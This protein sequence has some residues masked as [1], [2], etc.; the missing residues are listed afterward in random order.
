MSSTKADTAT[1]AA[2]K[3]PECPLNG[4]HHRKKVG[5]ANPT[6]EKLFDDGRPAI[7]S[8]ADRLSYE[9]LKLYGSGDRGCRWLILCRHGMHS[10][11]GDESYEYQNSFSLPVIA[12]L[13]SHKRCSPK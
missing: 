8:D 9:T 7:L 1:P 6:F 3:D 11:S 10:V 13:I 2:T 5:A 12:S 4:H